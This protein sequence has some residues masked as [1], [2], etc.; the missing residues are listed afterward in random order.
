MAQ[1]GQKW[2]KMA[3]FCGNTCYSDIFQ[4]EMSQ[5]YVESHTDCPETIFQKSIIFDMPKMA[6]N[7]PNLAITHVILIFSNWKCLK[8][9]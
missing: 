3:K 1:N 2:P 6:Q 7:G 9:M 5:N 4:L 8:I